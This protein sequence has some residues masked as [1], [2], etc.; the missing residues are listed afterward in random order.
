M[1]KGIQIQINKPKKEK[2][3]KSNVIKTK[4]FLTKQIKIRKNIKTQIE[5]EREREKI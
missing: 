3:L 1:N 5:K 4:H 2:K